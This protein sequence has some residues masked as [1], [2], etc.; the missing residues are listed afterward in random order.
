[1]ANRTVKKKDGQWYTLLHTYG[2]TYHSTRERPKNVLHLGKTNQ[3]WIYPRCLSGGQIFKSSIMQ[4]WRIKSGGV[5]NDSVNL[6][7]SPVHH[8]FVW[9]LR[10]FVIWLFRVIWMFVVWVLPQTVIGYS[11]HVCDEVD[12]NIF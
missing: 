5:T 4:G 3:L 2:K 6:L 7:L 8:S 1:M 11:S 12:I 10:L 9:V